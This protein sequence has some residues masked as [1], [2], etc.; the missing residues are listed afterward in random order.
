[1]GITQAFFQGIIDEQKVND[2]DKLTLGNWMNAG[3]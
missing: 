1:M 2:I 3:H